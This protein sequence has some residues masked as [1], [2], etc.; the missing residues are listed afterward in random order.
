MSSVAENLKHVHERIEAACLAAGRPRTSVRLLAASKRTDA[1]G[2]EAAAAA[3]HSLFGENR[4][5]SLRDK[6]LSVQAPVEWH[7]IGHLQKNKVKY[8]VGNAS[9]VHSLDSAA[10]AD[11]LSGRVLLHRGRMGSLPDLD[12]L[13][14]VRL[15][16]E[17][18]KTGAP[19]Q[20]ALGLCQHAMACPGLRLRG[21]MAIPPEGTP[22]HWFGRLADLAEEGRSMGLPLDELSMGMSG[23][24]EEAVACGATIL[25]LGT[26]VFGS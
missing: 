9:M 11:A 6:A 25:R 17:S 3:G 2:V 22:A 24:L 10:L 13:V 8:I 19:I 4:A 15:A 16:P 12:V 1:A 20:E 26:A 7:F 14:Q 18:E 5:Q 21:L 23:D